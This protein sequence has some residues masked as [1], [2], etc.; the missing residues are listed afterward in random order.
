MATSEFGKAFREARASG[1]KTF[2]F[3]GKSTQPTWLLRNK[4]L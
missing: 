4:S 1:D 2:T 3:K